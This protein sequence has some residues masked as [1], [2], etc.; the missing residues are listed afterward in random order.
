MSRGAQE[1]R[2]VIFTSGSRRTVL[3]IFILEAKLDETPSSWESQD[4]MEK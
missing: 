2:Y 1:T 3:N 4:K